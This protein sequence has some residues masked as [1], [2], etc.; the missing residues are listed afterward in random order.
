MELL[1]F[2]RRIALFGS[3]PLDTL[4]ALSRVLDRREL[5]SPASGCSPTAARA[6]ASISSAQGRSTSRKDG[7]M[8][9]RIG[10]GA[11]VGEM[12]L[13]DDAPRSATVVAAEDCTLLRLDRAAFQ[14]LTEDYP[15]ML[16]ELCKLLA[17]NLR[18]A[19]RRLAAV[20][21]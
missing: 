9:A 13:V 18:E 3:L 11:Y 20:D 4:L 17:A 10:P 5:S 14:A 1:L 19:N 7:R 12:A 15:A 8:L 16:R 6:T 21:R 2:L